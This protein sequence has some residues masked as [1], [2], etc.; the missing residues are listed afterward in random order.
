MLKEQAG[1]SREIA[2][3]EPVAAIAEDL[4]VNDLN[5]TITLTRT[6]QGVY[7]Q[8]RLQAYAPAECVRCLTP[9]QQRVSSRFGEMYHYPPERAPE[10]GLAIPEDMNLDFAPLVRE[11]MLLSIP[12]RLLCRPDCKGLCPK[13]GKNWNEG[14]CDCEPDE[15]ESPFSDLGRL[16]DRLS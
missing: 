2:V 12:M 13:C 8:G 15:G 7:A 16:K 10:D 3:A 6:P 9:L 1:Y 5:G 11:D 4:T 14:P